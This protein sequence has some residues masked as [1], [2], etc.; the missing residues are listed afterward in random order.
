[1]DEQAII[2]QPGAPA[3]PGPVFRRFRGEADCPTIVAILNA[4][5]AADGIDYVRTLYA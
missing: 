2:T 4:C 1:M 3:I 5:D